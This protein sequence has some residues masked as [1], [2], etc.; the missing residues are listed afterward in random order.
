MNEVAKIPSPKD[1]D[2]GWEGQFLQHW[3][4]R[5][6]I[7]GYFDKTHETFKD[8]STPL[9]S[10]IKALHNRIHDGKTDI[11]VPDDHVHLLPLA[12]QIKKD[13]EELI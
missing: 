10:A 11:P 5:H 4:K 2:E 8:D 9:W 7:D 12:E 13:L 6:Q 3:V 1:M